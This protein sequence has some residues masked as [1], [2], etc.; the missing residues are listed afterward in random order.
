MRII[1]G[2]PNP[3]QILDRMEELQEAINNFPESPLLNCW[4]HEL[5]ALKKRPI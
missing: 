1:W 3:E 5:E 2:I 4:E